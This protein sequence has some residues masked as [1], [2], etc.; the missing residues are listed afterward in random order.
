M[1]IFED[2]PIFEKDYNKYECLIES[3][4]E[5]RIIDEE[6]KNVMVGNVL[7]RRKNEHEES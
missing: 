7:I 4:I 2:Y 3:E 1:G 5:V 6:V